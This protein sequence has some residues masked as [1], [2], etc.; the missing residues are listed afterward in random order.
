[1]IYRRDVD[2]LRAVAVVPVVLYH[3]G[4][5]WVPGGFVGVDVFFVISGYLITSILVNDI[6]AG[7][8]S[9]SRFYERRIRRLFPALFVVL[10]ASSAAAVLILLP[11]PF[12]AFSR[13]LVA[14][15][16]FGSNILFWRETSYFGNS[17]S[18]TPLLHIWSLAVEEQFYLL[19]PL[20]LMLAIRYCQSA[21]KVLIWALLL[22]SLVLSAWM[23]K[24][25]PAAT[26]YLLPPR[27]WELLIGAVLAI[28][29]VPRIR[30]QALAEGAAALGLLLIAWGVFNFSHDTVFPGPNAL[31]PCLG[32]ALILHAGVRHETAVGMLLGSRVF[33]GIGLISYSLYLWHWPVLV[34]G[35]IWVVVSL[36][37][38]QTTGLVMLSFGLAAASWRWVEQPFRGT[39]SL[40]LR[41]RLFRLATV[42]GSVFVGFGVFGHVTRGLPERLP[43]HAIALAEVAETRDTRYLE[44][45]RFAG[46]P[47]ETPCSRGGDVAPSIAL[48]GDSHANVMFNA[49]AAQA[50]AVGTSI[51]FFGT[52]GCPPLKGVAV[53]NFDCTDQSIADFNSIVGNDDFNIVIMIARYSVFVEGRSESLGPAE[54]GEASPLLF[55]PAR[56][57]TIPDRDARAAL[58]RQQLAETVAGLRAAGKSVVL[59]YPIPET[60]YNIPRSMA[61]LAVLGDF[62]TDRIAPTLTQFFDRQRAVISALDSVG[63]NDQNIHRVHPANILCQADHCNV[64]ISEGPLYRDDDHLSDLGAELIAP[65][66]ASV[67]IATEY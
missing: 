26:F 40:L 54:R 35:Q 29:I 18:E 59:V 47:I 67:L 44:C 32:A 23:V 12:A 3:A 61:Q 27:A 9:L 11:A 22:V 64:A 49:L 42:I 17:A 1:M 19:F 31:F 55:N 36:T 33:V 34:F 58:M 65:A 21:W 28:G 41:P 37:P 66:F 30:N 62:N 52:A 20:F 7:K 48:W 14:T 51:T 45:L 63:L 8:F 6:I 39:N 46:N 16:M 56:P 10:L 2:G 5:T 43:M 38:L 15:V 57:E 50:E 60:G 53:L 24:V 4:L 25:A 13:S